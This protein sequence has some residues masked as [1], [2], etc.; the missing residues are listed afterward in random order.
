[1]L[2]QT[3]SLSFSTRV[4]ALLSKFS[5]SPRFLND[6]SKSLVEIGGEIAVGITGGNIE[7]V[8]RHLLIGLPIE[9]VF[10]RL[11]DSREIMPNR[12]PEDLLAHAEVLVD[13]KIPHGPHVRPGN[14]GIA[15]AYFFRHMIGCFPDNREATHDSID[16][17]LILDEILEGHTGRVVL[18]GRDRLQDVLYAESP[19][20]KWHA[21]PPRGYAV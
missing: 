2:L 1:L 19:I 15:V 3:G 4:F 21:P 18:D 11:H 8:E 9:K 5:D 13:D 17:A 14:V 6:S 7:L 12:L 16:G 10:E 20:S